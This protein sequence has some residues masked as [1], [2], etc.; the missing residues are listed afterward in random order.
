MASSVQ[1]TGLED[2]IANVEAFGVKTLEKAKI[3]TEVIAADNE[4]HAKQY[5]PWHDRTGNARHS[6]TGST[7][8]DA[9]FLIAALAIG[10][11]YGKYLELSNGSKYAIVWPT[12][13]ARRAAMLETLGGIMRS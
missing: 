7:G 13:T 12:I 5:A 3:A 4:G 9:T 6:I 8:Q 11:F 2:V 1:L 10:V